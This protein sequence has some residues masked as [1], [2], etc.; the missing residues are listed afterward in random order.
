[1]SLAWHAYRAIAPMLGALAPAARVFAAPHERSLLE[2]RM[3]RIDRPGGCHA[4]IHG[5]SLGEANAVLPLVRELGRIQPGARFHLTATSRTG[6]DRLQE[7]G[8]PSTLAP[9]DAPQ[10]VRR[11]F[12]GVQ[13]ERVFIVETELWPHWLLRAASEN[14]PVAI[15]SARLSERSVRRY[16]RLGSSFRSLVAGLGA[17]LA[18][19]PEDA[20]RWLKIG[21]RAGRVAVVGNLKND[22]LPSPAESRA[23]ARLELGLD[24][25][26]PLIVA[27]S[28]RP[29]EGR[30][31]AE[32][33]RA[34]DPPL[35]RQWQLVV[36][37]RHPRAAAELRDEI[38]GAGIELSA[39]AGAD[40]GSWGF[41][42]RSGVLVGYYRAA[43]VALVGGSL[44]PYGGHNPLEPAA[45]GSAVIVGIHHDNQRE[46]V[47]EL[48]G[49][50]AVRIVPDASAL[51]LALSELLGDSGAREAAGRRALAA[52]DSL[53]GGAQRAA[54]RLSALQLWP[55]S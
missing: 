51:T 28:L 27:G 25:A 53:R 15:V 30:I 22:S 19:T 23:S 40:A 44:L 14:V 29:G 52:A 26:R 24:P 5:A 39:G 4:W 48:A 17:V 10:S 31:L 34:L 8:L 55:A 12:E 45:C 47:R 33:W 3:G 1:V 50:D 11:F 38:H 20:A 32:A 18:Q 37:P 54:L 36:V 49:S 16:A 43:E 21:A 46:A 9:M 2:E 42:P 41:D 6:R 13:P 7:S 35:A